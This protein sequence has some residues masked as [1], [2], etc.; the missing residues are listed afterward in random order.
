MT[1]AVTDHSG[2]AS[3]SSPS[4]RRGTHIVGDGGMASA[5]SDEGKADE[6]YCA[7][8]YGN[9]V[10]FSNETLDLSLAGETA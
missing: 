1:E 6:D 9:P 10:T 7:C 4:S 3:G 2:G 5:R 8:F